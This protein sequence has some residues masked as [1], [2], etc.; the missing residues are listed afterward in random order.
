MKI[1]VV[2]IDKMGDMILTL[3]VI[4]GLK[5]ANEENIIDVVCSDNNLKVCNNVP[6]I[7]NIFL[8][9]IRFRFW[10]VVFWCFV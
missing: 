8:F 6:I 1:C 2:R 5:K 7:N 3:P 4:Q 10:P 9:F